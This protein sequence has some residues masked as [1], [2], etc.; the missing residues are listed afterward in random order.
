MSE[1]KNKSEVVQVSEFKRI[2]KK[3]P[4]LFVLE[5]FAKEAKMRIRQQETIHT[6]SGVTFYCQ[7]TLN[8][9]LLLP[10][11]IYLCNFGQSSALRKCYH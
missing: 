6:V 3:A 5:V 2:Y 8:F 4:P 11:L 1:Q 7:Q 9:V 10:L